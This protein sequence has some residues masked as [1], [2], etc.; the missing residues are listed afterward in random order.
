MGN[1]TPRTATGKAKATRLRSAGA[2][3]RQEAP[4]KAA[5]GDAAIAAN[6]LNILLPYQRA[7]VE[8]KSRFLAC[9][10]SRQSGKSFT[11]AAREARR[12]MSVP[13][14]TVVI[15]APS[16]RQSHESLEKVKDWLRAFGEAYA[17]EE[18]FF[19][20]DEIE[21]SFKAKAIKLPNE[22]RCIAVPGRPD[23][24]RGFSGDI[25]LDEF[26]FFEDPASTWKAIVPSILNPLR[27]GEKSFI[28]TSTPNG[29]GARGKRF[30]EIMTGQAS[31]KWAT[32]LVPLKRAIADGLPVD[33]DEMCALLA[34]PL[35][36]AQ[37]LDCEFLDDTNELLPYD[38]IAAATSTEATLTRPAE[39]WQQARAR[40]AD[41]RLGIDFG[42]TNDPT[43]CVA[44]EKV[45]DIEV[46]REV[47]VLR[48][49]P[50]DEQEAILTTRVGV[51]VRA[52]HD[53]TGPGI[54]LGDYLVRTHGEY[55][56]T[57]HHLGKVELCRFSQQFKC[58][59]FPRLRRAFEPPVVIRIPAD[60]ALRDDLHAMQQLV[61]GEHFS[62]EAPRTKEGHSDRCTALALAHR[63]CE[64]AVVCA[65]QS[66]RS[67][68]TGNPRR[69]TGARQK[70][71]RTI[72]QNVA[73]RHAVR[74]QIR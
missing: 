1:K 60:P 15:A 59:I 2:T 3:P 11:V 31:G 34:D 52:C 41:I 35:A 45:G 49:M 47:L 38:L 5:R 46:V 56:P 55:K 61:S 40:R 29:K 17:D 13:K 30:Y 4:A 21:K 22:S 72:M 16:E 7:V 26:A 37:E 36:I 54:G 74:G 25:W 9:C 67:R 18:E 70:L 28:I 65:P 73:A 63:A 71:N 68:A 48:N 69:R 66:Y 53:Y 24:V 62:Y 50:T 19:S 51:C 39:W 6:P 44:L 43:V 20:G 58:E 27:G 33:Y 8:D 64:G 10:F 14:L 42:R 57:G 32:H 12:L 23:T